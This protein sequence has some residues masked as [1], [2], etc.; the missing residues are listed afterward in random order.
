LYSFFILDF[1]GG[2]GT[3]AHSLYEFDGR[4]EGVE[5]VGVRD[6]NTPGAVIAYTRG[7]VEE[8]AADAGLSVNKILPGYWSAQGDYAVNEQDLVVLEAT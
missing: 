4:L 3:S 6:V 1:Y 8:M 5:G 2:P 7:R